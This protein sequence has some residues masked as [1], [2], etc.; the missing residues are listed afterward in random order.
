MSEEDGVLRVAS[1]KGDTSTATSRARAK[2]CHH[3]RGVRRE[4]LKSSGSVGGLGRGE[5]IYAVRFIGDMGYVVTFE[6][7]D[8]LYTVDLSDPE[9]P[10]ATGELKIPG[11]SAYLHP[12]ADGRLLGIGQDGTLTGGITGPQASL[13]D[14]ADPEQP[15]RLDQL[16]IADGRYSST[17]TEW[18]HH[19]FLYSPEHALAVVPIT[20]YRSGSGATAIRV[21]PET[22]LERVA[23]LEDESPIQRILVVDE[24]LVTVSERGVEVRPLGEL[25]RPRS[26]SGRASRA[27]PG[28]RPSAPPGERR[29]RPPGARG[30]ARAWSG[31]EASGPAT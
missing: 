29:S 6:Q 18:D 12:V 20:G 27:R 2:A 23:T 17:A 4:A 26:R 30:R 1:T 14:V 10:E 7:T 22:G 21:D 24:N 15:E 8:P 16:A 9:D 19:A 11:Y 28:S 25:A 5:D 3:P 13:F 31:S